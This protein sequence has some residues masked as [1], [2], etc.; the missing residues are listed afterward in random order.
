MV[1]I[2]ELKKNAEEKK[3]LKIKCFNKIL[4]LVNNKIL[5]ISKTDSTSTWYEI[6]LFLLGYPTY[7]IKDC[8]K[9]LITKLTK[10]G[11]TVNYLEPNIILISW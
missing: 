2:Q 5:I 6:P 10:N 3:K 4:E 1:N 9:Y 7:E 8:S 11:F